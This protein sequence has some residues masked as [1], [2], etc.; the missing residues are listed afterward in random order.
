M[1]FHQKLISLRLDRRLSRQQVAN[2]L[3]IK[4]T[5]IRSYEEDRAWPNKES[6]LKIA[7]YYNVTLDDLLCIN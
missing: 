5:T 6:L 1:T 4:E 3:D 7:K 2:A